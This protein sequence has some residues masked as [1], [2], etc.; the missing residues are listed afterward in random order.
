[1]TAQAIARVYGV[2]LHL[3]PRSFRHE[4]GA[5]ME[6]LLIDQLREESAAIVATRAALD[7]ALTL[8]YRHLE[9]H[10]RTP[11]RLIPITFLVLAAAGLA[12]AVLGGSAPAAL[13]P[14]V[15]IAVATGAIGVIA[16][17]RSSPVTEPSTAASWWKFLVAGPS[18]ILGVI[19][20]AGLGVNAW[21]FGIAVVLTGIGAFAVGIVL[22]VAHLV[23][24]H[25][26][27]AAA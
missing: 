25:A 14:G 17:R 18:L 7:L 4:Y 1:M 6:Q 27:G 23:K 12:A 8:P 16:W 3:Y 20:A 26:Y 5:D 21:F 11:D 22:G 9:A 24:T 13:V 15:L 2:A 10:M 19:V